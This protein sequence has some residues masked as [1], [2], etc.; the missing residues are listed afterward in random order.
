MIPLMQRTRSIPEFIYLFHLQEHLN[1]LS[2]S[3]TQS[4]QLDSYLHLQQQ[5]QKDATTIQPEE[6]EKLLKSQFI[7]LPS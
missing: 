4:T 5:N 7:D 2:A 1:P 6:T 3:A